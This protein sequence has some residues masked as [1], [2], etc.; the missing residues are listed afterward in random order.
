RLDQHLQGI[1]ALE[2][3]LTGAPVGAACPGKPM[4]ATSS[5]GIIDGPYAGTLDGQV[6][7][8]PLAA[9]QIDLLA[10]ALACDQTRVFTFRFSPCNDF[11]VYPGFPSFSPDPT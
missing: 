5:Y 6:Q 3:Q 11:T 2:K 1:L 8:E 7:W 9:A 10:F 4:K